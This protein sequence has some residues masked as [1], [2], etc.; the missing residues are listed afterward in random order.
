MTVAEP[1]WGLLLVCLAQL[2]PKA[3]QE[4]KAYK[5]D[6]V[7]KD[8]REQQAHKDLREQRDPKALKVYKD[9]REQQDPKALQVQEFKAFKVLRVQEALVLRVYKVFRE[10]LDLRELRVYK[11]FKV[12]K[13]QLVLKALKVY[14]GSRDLVFKV[15]RDLQVQVAELPPLYRQRAV[16]LTKLFILSVFQEL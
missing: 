12:F 7:Y 8:S 14:K 3:L 6:R 5:A 1:G 9:S 13:E 10:P 4:L 2:V 15:S 16:Q 11:V